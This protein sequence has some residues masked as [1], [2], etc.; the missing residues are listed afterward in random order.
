MAS[1]ARIRN[2]RKPA[3]SGKTPSL[4]LERALQRQGYRI[5]AGMDEVGRG[6][7][8]GPVSVGVVC[9]GASVRSAPSGVRDSK[10]LTATARESMIEPIKRWADG[11]GVGH[12][13]P[14]EIDALG[15]IGALRLAGSRALDSC[16][17]RPDLVILDGKH[18]WLTDPSATGLLGLI[19]G[20]AL[21]PPVQTRIKADLTCSSV[22]AASVLAKV[23]RDEM[24]A[25]GAEKHPGYR[26]E[27]NK[28]Y[29]SAAHLEALRT[30]GPS[31]WHRRSWNLGV[32]TGSPPVTREFDSVSTRHDRAGE[33]MAELR[34]GMRHDGTVEVA[35]DGR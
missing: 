7:L 22:A 12:A 25:V 10:L 13:F 1:A 14:D 28:G 32:P 15:I 21:C 34:S 6:A 30:K 26:W 11:W 31:E 35:V 8:A 24:M 17:L 2:R 9:V 3:A 16:G 18:D 29:G 4:R 19:E 23:E 33:A 27:I 5:I 20:A